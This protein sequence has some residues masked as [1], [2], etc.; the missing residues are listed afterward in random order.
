MK[1]GIDNSSTLEREL[2]LEQIKKLHDAISAFNSEGSISTNPSKEITE[3]KI[4]EENVKVI[5]ENEKHAKNEAVGPEEIEQVSVGETENVSD[6]SPIELN[7]IE[8]KIE[9]EQTV[10]INEQHAEIELETKRVYSDS[11]PTRDLKQVIDLNKSFILRAE[12]FNNDNTEYSSFINDLNALQ[13]EESSFK[14]LEQKAKEKNWDDED[15]AFELLQRA[16]EKRFL[17]LI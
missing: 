15:K 13:S 14:L 5:I 12:L 7:F 10:S 2:L 6:K 8:E 1:D 11:K 3:D 16:V 9:P 17:P 4:E